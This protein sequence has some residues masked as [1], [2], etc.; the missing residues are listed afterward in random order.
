[1]AGEGGLIHTNAPP[2]KLKALRCRV[3][4]ADDAA[5]VRLAGVE[6]LRREQI[7]AIE[8]ARWL[9]L[10]LEKGGVTQTELAEELKVSQPLIA[11]RLRLLELP[12]ATAQLVKRRA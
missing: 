8:E 10:M 1:M 12:E 3:V 2:A 6:N 5:A 7:N 11:N 4:L 9:K